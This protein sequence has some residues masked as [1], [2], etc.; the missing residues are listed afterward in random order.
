MELSEKELVNRIGNTMMNAGLTLSSAE[1][2]TG[3]MVGMLLTAVPGSSEWFLG[4]V[5]AYSNSLKTSVLDVPSA[6]IET[7]GAVSR[8]AAVAMAAGIRKLTGS[9]ISISVTGIAGPDGGTEEKP[10]GTVWMAVCGSR[11]VSAEKKLFE[12]ERD[13]VRKKAADYLLE[14]LY[15]LLEKEAK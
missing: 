9:D 13:V 4:G 8:E 14:K 2:C 11:T 3:G 10:V 12:G 7:E 5:T 15:R 1:S 6:L